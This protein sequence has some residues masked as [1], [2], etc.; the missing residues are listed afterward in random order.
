MSNFPAISWRELVT[1]W[2]DDDDDDNVHFALDQHAQFHFYSAS[3]L[4]QHSADRHVA[5][6]SAIH[7]YDSEPTIFV[8]SYS[9]MLCA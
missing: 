5:P 6:L 9:L 7:Y 8:C 4:K 2:G 3:S 1:F